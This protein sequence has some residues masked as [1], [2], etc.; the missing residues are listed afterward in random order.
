[1]KIL[2][3]IAKLRK[4]QVKYLMWWVK[5]FHQGRWNLQILTSLRWLIRPQLISFFFSIFLEEKS[6]VTKGMLWQ[7]TLQCD[8]VQ[9]FL[10]LYILYAHLKQTQTLLLYEKLILVRLLW[11][12]KPPI[13]LLSTQI[14][15][16]KFKL[17]SYR[18]ELKAAV[19]TSLPE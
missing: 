14:H 12:W 9:V 5:C 1:M 2:V 6:L 8:A 4:Y 11:S 17:V 16:N 3:S 13:D 10:S 7:L 19:I 15:I 18:L